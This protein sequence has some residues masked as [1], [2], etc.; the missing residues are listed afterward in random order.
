MTFIEAF[1]LAAAICAIPGY[2]AAVLGNPDKTNSI[3][4]GRDGNYQTL[5]TAQELT[6][7]MASL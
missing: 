3:I 6:Q 4:V 1:K 2:N 5:H 7:F